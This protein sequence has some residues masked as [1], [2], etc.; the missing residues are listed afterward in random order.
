MGWDVRR[1]QS[2]AESH[3]ALYP[4]DDPPYFGWAYIVAHQVGPRRDEN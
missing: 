4:R 3:P 1:Q 2:G